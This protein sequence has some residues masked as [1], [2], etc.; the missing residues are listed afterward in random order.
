MGTSVAAAKAAIVEVLSSALAAAG[1]SEVL[2]CWGAPGP[3][4]PADAVAVGDVDTTRVRRRAGARTATEVH[5][6]TLI[7]GC[8]TQDATGQEAVTRRALALLDVIDG[9]L[10][11]DASE[12]LS[13]TARA[14]GI[15]LGQLGGRITVTETDQDAAGDV[16]AGRW[17]TVETTVTVT[18]Y[19]V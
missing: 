3:W 17:A 11:A 6:V 10:R 15:T 8:A 18:A 5:E 16:K 13:D 2:V 19:R 7:V 12:S 9:A 4:L 14:A 1:E